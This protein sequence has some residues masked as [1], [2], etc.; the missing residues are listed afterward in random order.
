MPG[1]WRNCR[2]GLRWLRFT[3]WGVVLAAL[4]ALA[5][6]NVIGLPDFVKTRLV[7]AL[8]QHDLDL[9]FTRMRLRFIRGF[10]AENVRLGQTKNTAQS[11]FTAGEV[12]LRLDYVALLHGD[13]QLTGLVVRDG[14]LTLPSSPTNALALFN[15][16]TGLRFE[17]NDVWSLDDFRADFAGVKFSLIGEMAHPLEVRNWQMFAAGQ[18]NVPTGERGASQR[19]LQTIS[20]RIAEIHFTESPQVNVTVQGDA[21]DVHSF[22]VRLNATAPDVRTPWFVAH[23]LQFGASLTAPV[24]APTNA[25]PALTWWTNL[26]PFRLAWVARAGELHAKKMSAE[27]VEILGLWQA[28]DLAVTKCSARLAGGP[29][30]FSA[31]LNVETRE[32]TFTNDAR[33]DPHALAALLPENVRTQLAEISWAQPPILR[34]G[35]SF[36]LPAWT[37][38]APDWLGD[39]TTTANVRGDLALTNT[40]TRGTKV[41]SLQTKFTY[42]NQMLNLADFSLTH[43]RTQLQFDGEHSVATENFSF[44]VRGNFAAASVD[45]FL[46]T[47]MARHGFGLIHFTE[48]LALDLNGSGNWRDFSRFNSAGHIALTNFAI[49]AQNLDSVVSDVAYTNLNVNFLNIVILRDG[50]TQTGTADCLALDLAKLNLNITNGFSTLPLQVVGRAIGPKTARDMDPYEFLALPHARVNGCIPV[51]SINNDLVLDDAD[52][53]VN[54]IGTVPFRWHLFE[55]PRI[56]GTVHWL[57]N[58]LTVTNV[59]GDVYGG[60][61]QGWGRFNLLTPGPG[62]DLSFYVSGTNVDF[63]AM[64]RAL[65]SPTNKLEGALS[66]Y[67]EVTHANS[68]DWRSWNGFGAARLHDGLLWDIRLFGLA[69]PVLNTFLPGLGNSRATEATA[70]AT[71]TNGIIFSDSLEIRSLLMRLQYVGTVDL[72]QNVNAKVTAQLLRNTWG[73]GP[74]MSAVLWPVSKIFECQVTGTLGDPQAK[75]VLLLPR[76]LMAPLHPIRSVE[77]MFTPSTTT[78]TPDSK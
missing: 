62:T 66:G 58:Y 24:S 11:E 22:V 60:N 53:W 76:L 51:H 45:P 54:V 42:A 16:Q 41:E 73:L 65:W 57:A 30:D 10:V 12:Q 72:Q 49:R 59:E 38:N 70:T 1:F 68:D 61:A 6:F 34:A 21:R 74:V 52:L 33:F 75:P 8:R 56:T 69:S 25:D 28:P 36:K 23:N 29:L 71:M 20:D 26:Q 63:H 67:M 17:K 19:L 9:Q 18:T 7:A 32:L 46:Q 31:T 55:T 40:V 3:L 77:E 47:E 64:G 48:P 2:T 78:N 43:G 13:F 5:W 27:T 39:L 14:K 4:L 44:H 50:G 37:N 15:V 35:G